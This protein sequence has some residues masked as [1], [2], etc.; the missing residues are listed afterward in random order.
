MAFKKRPKIIGTS[1][2]STGTTTVNGETVNVLLRDDTGAIMFGFGDVTIANLDSQSDFAKG[3]LILKTD[4]GSGTKALHENQG[5][6]AS[7]SFNLVGDISSAEISALDLET[8]TLTNITDTEMLIGTGAGTANYA[9]MSGDA[10]MAN[11][12]AVTV[13][14]AS[15]TWGTG[16]TTTSSGPGA[17]AITGAI[18][19][20]TTTGTGDALTLADGAE[21]QHLYVVYAAEGAGADTAVLTPT[22]LAGASTTVTF[23]D[24]GDS[25]HLL[26]TAG[27]WYFL[28][29]AAVV[30]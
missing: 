16:G 29:G 27:E 23:N 28:G 6:A 18:H 13:A 20:V 24:L 17:V 22:N 8:L 26:F 5:T 12:G 21:G 3:A 11:T 9:A 4:A 19:E 30:A 2:Q 10:T 15:G 14:S 1:F 7:S 25:A